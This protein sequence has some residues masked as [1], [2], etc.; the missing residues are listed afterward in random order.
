VPLSY[1]KIALSQDL[2]DSKVPDEPLLESW[3]PPIFRRVCRAV[4]HRHQEAHP[5][6]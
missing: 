3:S 5:A 4:R 2:L 6:P 1:A